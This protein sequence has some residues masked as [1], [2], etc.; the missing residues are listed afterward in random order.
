MCFMFFDFMCCIIAMYVICAGIARCTS[1]DKEDGNCNGCEENLVP[2]SN[3]C[4]TP[5]SVLT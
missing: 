3:V 1:Y 5:T 4:V 2:Q